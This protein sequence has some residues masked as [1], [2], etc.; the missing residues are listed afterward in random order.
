MNN[1]LL[2][3]QHHPRR[4][5]VN[6]SSVPLLNNP[7][8]STF[9]Y[10]QRRAETSPSSNG[11][12]FSPKQC[13]TGD[14][15]R[16]SSFGSSESKSSPKEELVN[17]MVDYIQQK[18]NKLASLSNSGEISS[19]D[20][21]DALSN[22]LSSTLSS[23]WSGGSFMNF[24]EP[25]K[26]EEEN[27]NESFLSKSFQEP[28]SQFSNRTKHYKHWFRRFSLEDDDSLSEEEINSKNKKEEENHK[29]DSI[30]K[31][32]MLMLFLLQHISN[33][34]SDMSFLIGLT[35][36]LYSLGYLTNPKFL[37]VEF[38]KQVCKSMI[39]DVVQNWPITVHYETNSMDT[40]SRCGNTET[41]G[42]HVN[43]KKQLKLTRSESHA[44]FLSEHEGSP[45]SAVEKDDDD[46]E[47]SY[48]P[49]YEP[50]FY[51]VSRFHSDF[52][53]V[54]PINPSKQVPLHPS[55][56]VV[57]AK[58]KIDGRW[59]CIKKVTF[60]F[61][62]T[63]ELEKVYSRVVKEVRVLASLD[64]LNVVRY[65]QA[66]FEPQRENHHDNKK[67][68]TN[69][70]DDPNYF[71]NGDVHK[72][73][74]ML[75]KEEKQ[76]QTPTSCT[77]E[78]E[79]DTTSSTPITPH[80][81]KVG[82][83]ECPS[84]PPPNKSYLEFALEQK[85]RITPKKQSTP[86]T[87]Q[88]HSHATELSSST[89][90]KDKETLN[91]GNSVKHLLE[92]I[93]NEKKNKF[94]MV[95]YIVMQLCEPRTLEDYLTNSERL[96]Q[97]K[98]N[99]RQTMKIFLQ[100]VDGV[101]HI[102]D[103]KLIHRDLKPSNIFLNTENN[104]VKIGGFESIF[105]KYLKQTLTE[106]RNQGATD[107]KTNSHQNTVYHQK[108]KHA[109]THFSL[110]ASPEQTFS[111]DISDEK[112]DIYSLGI[113]LFELFCKFITNTERVH[114]LTQLRRKMIIPDE[115]LLKYPR[116]MGLVKK[117]IN[118]SAK[119]RPTAH[120]IQTEV[121][122]LLKEYKREAKAKKNLLNT[123]IDILKE[124]NRIIEQQQQEILLLKQQLAQLNTKK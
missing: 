38:L 111:H 123:P 67:N 64:H 95:L 20:E 115:M 79:K 88:V 42:T 118:P 3:K 70:I 50:S 31:R 83:F 99:I 9:K 94:E 22:I 24:A 1:K 109:S 30:D 124:K 90:I 96:K 91:V 51:T 117:C 89:H 45:I 66:W 107:K 36:H 81:L 71:W 72:I 52:Y 119:S 49:I 74:E 12:N 103:R 120:E 29:K 85:E 87:S 110:Y 69:S 39:N 23:S 97:K 92:Q 58:G 56:C 4:Y 47:I 13:C 7:S 37:D 59:Y 25:K 73:D 33:Q 55:S 104:L 27:V 28:T 77:I 63:A 100:I 17:E 116:E 8:T 6:T 101:C 80:H 78:F 35:R 121:T 18:R 62:N 19:D 82:R 53:K 41:T 43:T 21:G 32:E 93:F 57:K 10:E 46:E 48:L 114:V 60:S 54:Q 98:M 40:D 102:H 106:S 75:T 65:Y 86:L 76:C 5:T 2:T 26:L 44:S 105:I 14:V 68:I 34:Y 16:P 113:I 61:K 108:L 11:L 122:N 112:A 15:F 84:S